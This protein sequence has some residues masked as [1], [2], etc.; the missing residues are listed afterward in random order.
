M[1]WMNETIMTSLNSRRKH[2]PGHMLGHSLKRF[3]QR[4]QVNLGR[5]MFVADHHYSAALRPS[6]IG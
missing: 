3:D 1:N 2:E 6:V 5:D 4:A